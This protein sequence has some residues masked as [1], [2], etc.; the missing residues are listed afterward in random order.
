MSSVVFDISLSLST[1]QRSGLAEEQ[2]VGR[3]IILS[4]YKPDGPSP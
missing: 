3:E 1:Y 4:K 2:V